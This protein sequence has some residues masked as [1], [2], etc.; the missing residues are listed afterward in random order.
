MPKKDSLLRHL[1]VTDTTEIIAA[2]PSAST[3]I[4]R[5]G[6]PIALA[7][8]F[9]SRHAWSSEPCWTSKESVAAS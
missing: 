1:T 8:S 9:K 6:L 7:L 2:A 3:N 4:R 5:K